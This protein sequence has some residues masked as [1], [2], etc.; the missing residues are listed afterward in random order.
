VMQV[1]LPLPERFVL[2]LA[3]F[4]YLTIRQ[5]MR[6]EGY[7]ES[8]LTY[9]QEHIKPLVSEKY[10]FP[11]VGRAV[12]V[13]WVY[14]LTNKGR[15]YAALLGKPTA[16]R[17]RPS[18]ETSKGA[19]PYFIRHALLISDILI[20]AR[21]L[22]KTEPRIILTRQYT[23]REL[24][25]KINVA[26]PDPANRSHTISLEPDGSVRF[27]INAIWQAF[28]HIEV[29][30]NLPPAE[31]RFKQKVQGYVASVKTGQHAALFHTTSLNIAVFA[32]T[33]AMAATLREWTE[34]SLHQQPEEG[35]R[36]FFSS[37]DVAAATPEEIFLSLGW[38][39]AFSTD[40]T[41]LLVLE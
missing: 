21:L 38:E 26:L 14:T 25:R 29:Y 27:L 22:T 11:L 18:E 31:W 39:Q 9:G 24:R 28:F 1:K 19:N 16:K 33:P 12:N 23:E 13:P 20:A 40:K 36:F 10:V 2:D 7:A 3:E 15:E 34:E 17:F 41:P 32:Q 30:R 5:L 35:G 6:L 8:S 4:D 37:L